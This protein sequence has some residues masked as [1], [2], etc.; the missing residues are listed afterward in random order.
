MATMIQISRKLDKQGY[1]GSMSAHNIEYLRRRDAD[2]QLR[3]MVSQGKDLSGFRD[4]PYREQCYAQA[5]KN[6]YKEKMPDRPIEKN[7]QP[8]ERKVSM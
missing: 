3:A 6:S 8:Y 1:P 2:F 7:T 5:I 4:F